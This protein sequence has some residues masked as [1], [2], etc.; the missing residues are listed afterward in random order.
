M[1]AACV[2][3][4]LMWVVRSRF[5]S[6]TPGHDMRECT[7]LCAPTLATYVFSLRLHLFLAL[8]S[9]GKS[10]KNSGPGHMLDDI[11]NLKKE[12]SA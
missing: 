2:A 10:Y 4:L 3:V 9:G 11:A 1:R 5:T 7:P 12:Q 6:T 8:R